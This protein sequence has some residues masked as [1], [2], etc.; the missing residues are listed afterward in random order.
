[1]QLAGGVSRQQCLGTKTV[2]DAVADGGKAEGYVLG[3]LAIGTLPAVQI[4]VNLELLEILD[5]DGSLIDLRL[6]FT[7]KGRASRMSTFV[8][9]IGGYKATIGDINLWTAS[10]GGQKQDWIFDGYPWPPSAT[11]KDKPADSGATSAV[12]AFRAAKSMPEAI[13]KIVDG[14]YDEVY[15]V[16]HSSGCAI[17]NKI[18]EELMV[19]LG[20]ISTVNVNLVALDGFRPSPAQLKRPTT[21]V[22]CAKDGKNEN[23]SKNYPFLKG[24]VGLKMYTAQAHQH[25]VASFLAGQHRHQRQDG[26]KQRRH[27]QR[28]LGLCGEPV[29][30]AQSICATYDE[31]APECRRGPRALAQTSGEDLKPAGN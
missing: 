25:M 4:S 13:N 1:V 16:G 8:L 6:F 21:Q 9:F 17:A 12:T 24:T 26:E 18:D 27:P 23:Q 15:I 5:K 29:L 28:L 10:A 19:A 2:A 22:W 31:K 3:A 20:E 14:K 30:D 7:V 11:D